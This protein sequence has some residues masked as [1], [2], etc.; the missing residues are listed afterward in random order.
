MATGD[1]PASTVA[2][3]K[4][5]YKTQWSVTGVTGIGYALNAPNLPDKTLHVL[6]P[7]G[8]T[9]QVVVEGTNDDTPTGDNWTTLV[10]PH[11]TDLSFTD[12]AIEAILENPRYIR[13]RFPVATG[14]A[15]TV[16][17]ISR[18]AG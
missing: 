17:I 14:P 9:T 13:P 6:G 8:G 18:G 3:A 7:T 11:E 16:T 10:D 15:V 12:E 4:G 5:V 2:I 1:I